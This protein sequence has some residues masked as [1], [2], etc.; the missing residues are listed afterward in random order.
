MSWGVHNVRRIAHLRAI[1][2]SGLWPQFWQQLP[3]HSPPKNFFA[4]HPVALASH[5]NRARATCIIFAS[6]L[7]RDHSR[8]GR[9]VALDI[10]FPRV[11]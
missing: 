8:K 6:F 10:I 1:Y 11:Q 3:M 7:A 9:F 2:K 5:L 4:T